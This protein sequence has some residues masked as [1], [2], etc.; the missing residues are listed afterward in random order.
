MTGADDLERRYRRLLRWYPAAFRQE[1]EDEFIGVLMAAAR[2]GQRR[3]EP[4]E[5]LD[6]ITNGLRQRLRQTVRHSERST[7]IAMRLMIV[8][9]ALELVAAI[10]VLESARDIASHL[11]GRSPGSSDAVVRAAVAGRVDFVALAAVV[12]AV[13]WLGLA[14]AIV[15]GQRWARKVCA[16]LLGVNLIGLFSGLAEGSATFARTSLAIGIVLCLVQLAAVALVVDPT[17]RIGG[18]L[19]AAGRLAARRS[20]VTAP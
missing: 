14:W 11:S 12:A 10:S 15:R 16:V 17:G 8:G 3:P 9:A 6:L 19:S 4:F 7:L 1:Y 18:L 5:C 2:P 20:R 13:V